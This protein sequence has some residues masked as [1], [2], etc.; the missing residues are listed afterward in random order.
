MVDV[1]LLMVLAFS[2]SNAKYIFTS[3]HPMVQFQLLNGTCIFKRVQLLVHLRPFS[4]CLLSD[5]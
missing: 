2:V 1:Y 5:T 4:Q 3:I